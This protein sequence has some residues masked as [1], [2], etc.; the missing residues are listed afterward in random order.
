MVTKTSFREFF[1][2]QNGLLEPLITGRYDLS[3]GWPLAGLRIRMNRKSR[4][5]ETV[6]SI[7]RDWQPY[8]FGA[9]ARMFPDRATAD[10]LTQDVFVAL[11]EALQR[12]ATITN[13]RPYLSRLIGR[14]TQA[15]LKERGRIPGESEEILDAPAPSPD[16]FHENLERVNRALHRLPPVE[17]FAIV[18]SHYLRLS[19]QEIA[20]LV[21]LPVRTVARRYARGI[22]RLQVW[23]DGDGSDRQE[24]SV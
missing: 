9:F 18:G 20:E 23:L 17:R 7:W 3:V 6:E 22:S 13:V 10:D 14:T 5:N 2:D 15:Y 12:G 1:F 21:G 4:L 19:R 11:S 16:A 8:V 24:N